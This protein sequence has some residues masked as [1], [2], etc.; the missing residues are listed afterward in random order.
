MSKLSAVLCGVA[1]SVLA[2]CGGAGPQEAGAEEVQSTEQAIIWACD[3]TRDF[4]RI[5]KQNGVEVGRE[6]C[7]CD[8]TLLTYGTLR[9]SYTQNLIR[10][11]N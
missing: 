9:G 11:C 6:S 3:G 1:V 5:W 7:Y 8:G 2:A 4:D 10:Y